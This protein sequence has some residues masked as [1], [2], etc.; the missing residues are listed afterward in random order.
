MTWV[1]DLR[2]GKNGVIYIAGDNRGPCLYA[3]YNGGNTWKLLKR[4]PGQGTAEGIFVDPDNPNRIGLSSVQWGGYSGGKIYWSENGGASWEDISGDLPA[5][6]GAA[7]IAFSKG[8]KALY[9]ARYAGSVYKRD[10]SVPG[11]PQ[12]FKIGP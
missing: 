11:P 12:S 2:I 4:F 3:S 1:F 5:G 9:I 6:T 10:I 7:A 8:R